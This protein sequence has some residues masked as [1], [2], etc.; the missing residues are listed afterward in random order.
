M[1]LSPRWADFLAGNGTEA[2]HWSS[3]GAPDAPDTGIMAY[4]QS[5]G[6]VVLTNDLDFGFVFAINHHKKPSVIQI[7]AGALG[8]EK[9]GGRVVGVLKTLSSGIEEGALVTVDSRK[10]RVHLFP[11]VH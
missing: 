8:P 6:F 11:I 1:N 3:V 9:I 7:R 5:H 2:V 4:A 10:V